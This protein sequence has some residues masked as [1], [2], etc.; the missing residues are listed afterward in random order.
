MNQ[1]YKNH[2]GKLIIASVEEVSEAVNLR[3]KISKLKN[4]V[5]QY[6]EELDKLQFSCKHDVFYDEPGLTYNTRKCYICNIILQ[7]I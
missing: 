6:S 2:D 5:N 7:H 3:N 4:L 1:L